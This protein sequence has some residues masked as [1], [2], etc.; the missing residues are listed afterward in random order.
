MGHG[1]L[2]LTALYLA[3]AGISRLEPL[4]RNLSF[5]VLG[6]VLL[7]ASLILARLRTRRR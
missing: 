5:L 7:T 4:F 6:T 1:T 2:V 3:I